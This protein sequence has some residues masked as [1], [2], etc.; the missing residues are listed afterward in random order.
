MCVWATLDRNSGCV[1]TSRVCVGCVFADSLTC[2]LDVQGVCTQD[3]LFALCSWVF[4]FVL[5][6]T[7]VLP[8][9]M[10]VCLHCAHTM[11]ALSPQGWFWSSSSHA[12]SWHASQSDRDP[13]WQ[14]VSV[15]KAFLNFIWGLI[16][17]WNNWHVLEKPLKYSLFFYS[18]SF[19]HVLS[20]LSVILFNISF[21]FFVSPAL[22]PFM[23]RQTGRCSL[24]RSPRMLW[25]AQGFLATPGR[26][27]H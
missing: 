13:W 16:A 25:W 1:L 5:V 7:C 17:L 11:S 2:L 3:C 9:P 23:W 26:S 24:C 4:V 10:G 20:E 19:F 21:P 15:F 22:T 12:S 8:I 27:T 18:I 14:T 6:L